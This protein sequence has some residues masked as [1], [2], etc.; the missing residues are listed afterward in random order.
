MNR[1]LRKAKKFYIYVVVFVAFVNAC[2]Y[3]PEVQA[4]DS[5]DIS[6]KVD[7]FVG[8]D[9]IIDGSTVVSPFPSDV[10]FNVVKISSTFRTPTSSSLDITQ[11]GDRFY[12]TIN[13]PSS[14]SYEVGTFSSNLIFRIGFSDLSSIAQDGYVHFP[15]LK[16]QFYFQLSDNNGNLDSDSVLGVF[17]VPYLVNIPNSS[18]V[19]SRIE[20]MSSSSSTWVVTLNLSEFSY[21]VGEN[22]QIVCPYTCSV[23]SSSGGSLNEWFSVFV[24]GAWGVDCYGSAYPGLSTTDDLENNVQDLVDGYNDSAGSQAASDLGNSASGYEQAEDNLFQGSES[25]L[26]GFEF[27]DFSG[28][29][30][31]T[32]GLSFVSTM[33][34]SI[35]SNLGGMSGIGIVISVLFSV[36]FLAIVIGL[37][38]YFK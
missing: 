23:Q 21:N 18:L 32:T 12:G 10:F 35:Y 2:F 19:Y 16:I 6:D 5:I 11:S 38:R 20:R 7:V 4:A 29:T 36:M 24:H 34:Q 33:M 1:R 13:W 15:D 17:D 22:F 28:Y 30:G 14:G 8:F 26:S 9:S 37:Y 25:S 27:F 31:I 3:C